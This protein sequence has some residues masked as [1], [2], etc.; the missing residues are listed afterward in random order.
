MLARR[1]DDAK[2]R[3]EAHGGT[4]RNLFLSPTNLAI[5]LQSFSQ[6]VSQ[7]AF[8]V[9]NCG[10]CILVLILAILGAKRAFGHTEQSLA[11]TVGPE[12]REARNVVGLSQIQQTL[13]FQ[14]QGA[15]PN[16]HIIQ[17]LSLPIFKKVELPGPRGLLC[18]F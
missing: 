18:C 4:A 14:M 15:Y 16:F 5:A 17:P 1:I 13:A 6:E 7:E 12:F 9:Q 8:Y 10:N 3:L 11:G 2:I